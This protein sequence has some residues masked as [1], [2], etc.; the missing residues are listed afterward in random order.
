MTSKHVS[1][2]ANE[3]AE[4]PA[5]QSWRDLPPVFIEQASA[6]PAEDA[7]DLAA[8]LW[9]LGE[10]RYLYAAALAIHHHPSALRRLRWKH[11]QPLGET[12]NHWGDV[13]MFVWLAGPAWRNGQISDA[14]VMRWT[15]SDN[16]W[17]R[18]AALVCTVYLNTKAR[19]GAGDTP[20]TLAV[21]EALAADRDAMVAKGLSWALRALI[22][23]DRRAVERFLTIHDDVLPAL[24]KREVRNKLTTGLKSPPRKGGRR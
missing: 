14:R 23:H 13:D 17:W 18:R 10:H 15:R 19:G 20:R 11:L 3:L 5:F 9:R 21:C 7:I 22:G 6:L 24:V 8:R 12:M 2:I 4:D 1:R 16:R